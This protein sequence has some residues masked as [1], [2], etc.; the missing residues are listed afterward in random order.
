MIIDIIGID[1]ATQDKKI[2]LAR[3][4]F[5]DGRVT[6]DAAAN[7]A[8]DSS[9]AKTVAGW[10]GGTRPVLIAIDAPL[11]WPAPMGCA[12]AVHRA[13]EP[14]VVK[15]N[16]LFRRETDRFIKERIDKQSLDVGADRIARTAHTALR[17][18]GE[19]GELI[20]EEIGLA[21]GD[22]DPRSVSAIEVY[23]AATLTAHGF[24]ATGYKDA[25]ATA[26]RKE[27]LVQLDQALE[28]PPE[29]TAMAGNADVLDAVVCLLAARDFLRGEAMRPT[30]AVTARKEGWIWCR[31][32]GAP[33]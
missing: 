31:P 3:G 28:L 23:P 16:D 26:A 10:I 19:I 7:C 20:N 9:A 1:C 6:V 25:D 32:K 22:L 33:P 29:R 15:A 27:I 11:G 12:L 4:V 14:I 21:W 18:L 8:R 24:L 30:D 13:G 17:L 2:G 5:V